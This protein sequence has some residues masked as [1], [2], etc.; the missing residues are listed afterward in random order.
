MHHFCSS[1]FRLRS[2]DM[3]LGYHASLRGRMRSHLALHKPQ[4]TRRYYPTTSC[5]QVFSLAAYLSVLSTVDIVYVTRALNNLIIRYIRIPTKAPIVLWIISSNSNKPIL[6][7]N[8]VTSMK[9]DNANGN[10]II[11]LLGD[12]AIGMRIPIGT[13]RTIF[14]IFSAISFLSPRR[15]I[16]HD[17]NGCNL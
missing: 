2:Q 15:I 1:P 6:L 8:C 4:N 17:H 7:N 10:P 3:R 9:T 5:F 13:N 14:Q 16:L 11:H 12:T